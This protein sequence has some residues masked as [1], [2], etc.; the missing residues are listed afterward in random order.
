VRGFTE[1]DDRGIADVLNDLPE[2]LFIANWQ[3]VLSQRCDRFLV[4]D[5][6]RACHRIE[7]DAGYA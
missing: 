4:H 6:P 3:S 1:Q 7:N 5:F 2:I